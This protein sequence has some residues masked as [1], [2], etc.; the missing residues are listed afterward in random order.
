MLREDAG[1]REE[2]QLQHGSGA[3]SGSGSSH[4]SRARCGRNER[5]VCLPCGLGPPAAAELG[6]RCLKCL[7]AATSLTAGAVQSLRSSPESTA[8]NAHAR[9]GFLVGAGRAPL[10]AG[11][12]PTETQRVAAGEWALHLPFLRQGEASGC[13]WRRGC[14]WSGRHGS[15]PRSLHGARGGS[16][17]RPSATQESTS[18][19]Q[20]RLHRTN[21]RPTAKRRPHKHAAA[22]CMRAPSGLQ[23]Q[24]RLIGCCDEKACMRLRDKA[25]RVRAGRSTQHPCRSCLQLQPQGRHNARPILEQ[26]AVG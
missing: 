16:A 20:H 18:L 6:G 5:N 8:R 23:L 25:A 17:L 15:L 2:L 10:R 4:G 9:L 13:R 1:R 14:G 24:L 7:A 3:S 11:E 12:R 22:S 21:G 19:P 26:T